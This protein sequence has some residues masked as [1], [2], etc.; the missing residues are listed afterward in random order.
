[1]TERV[2]KVKQR[3][4]TST[5]PLCVERLRIAFDV[6]EQTKGHPLIEVRARVQD[7]ILRKMPIFIEPDDIIAGVGASKPNGIEMDYE[8]GPWTQDEVDALKSEV[9]TI[10]PEDEA[11]LYGFMERYKKGDLGGTTF[12]ALGSI[13]GDSD[14]LW[15]YLKSGLTLPPFK[16]KTAGAGGGKAQSGMGMG[17]GEICTVVDYEVILNEGARSIIDRCKYQLKNLRYDTEDCIEKK[18]FWESAILIY[19]A[20]I[21]WANRYADLADQMAAEESDP[22]RAQ[23]LRDMAVRCRRVPEYPARDFRE[24]IQSFWFTFLMVV[25]CPVAGAGRVDQYFWPFYKKDLEEGRITREEALELLC[26][27]RLK[28]MQLNRLNGK[29]GRLKNSGMAKWHNFT[30]GGI[31][32]EGNCAVNDLT[33]LFMEAARECMVPHHTLSLRVHENTPIETIKAAIE[34]VRAGLGMPSFVSDSSYMDF[35]M[36]KGY[37]F[38]DASNYSISG[39]IMHTIGGLIRHGPGSANF[40][41]S[42]AFD[43]FMHDGYDTFSQEQVGIKTGDVRSFKTYEEFRDAFYK[44]MEYLIDLACQC[45]NIRLLSTREI[46]Q[47]TWY[48][49]LYKGGVEEGKDLLVRK[50]KPHDSCNGMSAVG[51]VNASDSLAAVKYLIYD[52][53]KYSM[54]QLVDALNADWEGYEEMRRDFINA[55]KYGNDD[56]YADQCLVD[57]YHHFAVCVSS[58]YNMNGDRFVPNGNSISSHQPGGA[59]IGATPD[60]RKKGEILADGAMSP[61]QGRDISGPLAVLKSAMKVDGSEFGAMLMNMK[62]HPTALQTDQDVTKLANALKV[63]MTHGGKQIQLNMIDSETLEA[64]KEDPASYKD[65]IV[66]VAGYSAYFT[67]LTKPIQNE[68]IARV[69]HQG[70]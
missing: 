50:F 32:R 53:Q 13:A 61:G 25:P 29:A 51:A 68:V 47:N 69:A 63:F 20:W 35:L 40:V 62:F 44:Q 15:P 12:S 38:A 58:H 42:K 60:G 9:Y 57:L 22:V 30:I 52:K 34:C 49:C 23:E 26:L 8:V 54:E 55:P 66:R 18:Q 14:T 10:E 19:E 21:H 36:S 17:P 48:S 64:A 59:I 24:A 70:V 45:T 5:F 6:L 37:D 31:D 41:I 16:D 4:L 67:L 65:L 46:V 1:M 33:Y 3:V 39:C 27:I 2:K 11:A 7:A 43:I 28:D 56:D